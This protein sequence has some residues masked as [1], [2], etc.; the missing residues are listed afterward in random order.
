MI[1]RKPAGWRAEQALFAAFHWEKR[2]GSE[3]PDALPGR[4][5]IVI[6]LWGQVGSLAPGTSLGQGSL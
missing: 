6:S 1:N 2:L 3:F 5:L 4:S